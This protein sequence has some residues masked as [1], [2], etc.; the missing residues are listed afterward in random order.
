MLA[1]FINRVRIF[2]EGQTEKISKINNEMND[3][4]RSMIGYMQFIF[5][6]GVG[7]DIRL[8][9]L[10]RYFADNIK[11]LG[12]TE[13]SG[14]QYMSLAKEVVK[15]PLLTNIGRNIFLAFIYIYSIYKSIKYKLT[16]GKLLF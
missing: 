5:G 11:S 6:P 3:T 4:N 12:S 15:S 10:S 14:K 9:N 13:K 8:F 7:K 16:V 1:I 2:Q